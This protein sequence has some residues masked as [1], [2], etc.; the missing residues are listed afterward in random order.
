M[1]EAIV[2]EASR[3]GYGIDQIADRALTVGEVIE[4]L[5]EYD[6]DTLFV[7]SHDNGYTYGSITYE[8]EIYRER[9]DGEFEYGGYD[10]DMDALK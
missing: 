10:G 4:M 6:P 7:L 8:G 2:F 5:S 3:N 9:P 1:R